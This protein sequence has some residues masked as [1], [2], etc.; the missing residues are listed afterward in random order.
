[1]ATAC[2][3]REQLDGQL[4]ALCLPP[5]HSIVVNG[6]VVMSGKKQKL[7][8]Y[9]NDLYGAQDK[10]GGKNPNTSVDFELMQPAAAQIIV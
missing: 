8:N 6:L 9:C 7:L 4:A 5:S 1:M 2:P 3:A 10:E